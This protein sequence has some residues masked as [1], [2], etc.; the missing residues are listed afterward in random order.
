MPMIPIVEKP[1]PDELLSSWVYRLS[2]KNGLNC[3][4]FAE[5]YLNEKVKN[6]SQLVDIRY[7]YSS[8]Y[9]N[10]YTKQ[11][12]K[13]L[14]LQTTTYQFESLWM[15]K[16]QQA[17]YIN[18]VFRPYDELNTAVNHMI[19]YVKICP[20][21]FKQDK[22]TYG[23]AYLHRMHQLSGVKICIIHKVKLVEYTNRVIG[24]TENFFDVCRPISADA[25]ETSLYKYAWYADSLLENN[26]ESSMENIKAIVRDKIKDHGSSVIPEI[27]NWEYSDLI[28]FNVS[29]FMTV[30]LVN[31]QYVRAEEIIPILMYLFPDVNEFIDKLKSSEPSIIERTCPVCDETYCTTEYAEKIGFGCPRCDGKLRIQDRY[32]FY[33]NNLLPD[34][35][36]EGPF[37]GLD[38]KAQFYH[39]RCGKSITL[40]PR[41]VIF[42]NKRCNCENII[43]FEAAKENVESTGEYKLLYYAK[44]EEPV[45]I[46][47]IK[48]G[49]DFKVSYRKFIK[50][51]YC[52]EC[53]RLELI[54]D[55]RI[56][57]LTNG[58]YTVT[59]QY[60]DQD[61]KV[62]I[63]HEICQKEQLY[64]PRHFLSGQRCKCNY[65][66]KLDEEW[67]KMYF[68]L[69]EYKKEHG[70]TDIPKRE[71]YKSQSLGR[72]VQRQRNDYKNGSL[73]QYRF[74]RLTEIGFVFDPHDTEWNR[75]L[76]Q[77]KRYIKQTG[78]TYISKR[79]DFEGEHLGAWVQTQKHRY[80]IGKMFKDKKIA[81]LE[82]DE[83][84]FK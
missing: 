11:S 47:N 15:T 45:T 38:N 77:Y 9:K 65:E 10:I 79:T 58:E 37:K 83:D 55:K 7:G 53:R 49:H 81:L 41:E 63:R 13:D 4:R 75:R 29:K 17:R 33:I 30:K 62:L 35:K 74:D 48:C 78:T 56:N 14:Y 23:T 73:R 22:V 12:L 16:G 71:S 6:P 50:S 28:R 67:N 66:N 46:H 34:Y 1:L 42:E 82:V 60:V 27:M 84:F 2:K 39:N 54:F 72:W 3:N 19:K 20:E 80:K 61:T 52:R 8:F 21:C 5:A 70:N 40:K 26:V 25:S 76:D 24:S 68:L 31:I 43:T 18:N 51:P 32:E 57:E 64:L 69:T 59:G 36:I 44:T